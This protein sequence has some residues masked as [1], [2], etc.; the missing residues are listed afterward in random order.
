M[1]GSHAAKVKIVAAKGRFLVSVHGEPDTGPC[2]SCAAL[3]DAFRAFVSEH[4][5]L[6]EDGV[7]VLDDQFF[8]AAADHFKINVRSL[9]DGGNDDG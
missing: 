4:A 2:P 9:F 1:T 7:P 6:G 3:A 5:A 8:T